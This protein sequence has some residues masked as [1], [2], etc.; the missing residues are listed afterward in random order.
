MSEY[1]LAWL[2]LFLTFWVGFT[3]G[4]TTLAILEVARRAEDAA[5]SDG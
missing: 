5:Q 2:E 4:A 3:F 1:T